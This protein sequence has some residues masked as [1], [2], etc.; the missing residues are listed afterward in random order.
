M[1]AELIAHNRNRSVDQ[2]A[3]LGCLRLGER[4]A[5]LIIHDVQR[6]ALKSNRHTVPAV[7]TIDLETAKVDAFALAG[8]IL[9]LGYLSRSLPRCVINVISS[10]RCAADDG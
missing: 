5:A 2:N 7:F 4:N 3:V 8:T 1:I 6:L 9:P 10:L